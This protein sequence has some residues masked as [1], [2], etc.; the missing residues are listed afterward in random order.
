MYI[1]DVLNYIYLAIWDTQVG[2][3]DEASGKFCLVVIT[4]EGGSC[5]WLEKCSSKVISVRSRCAPFIVILLLETI[6]KSC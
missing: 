4:E 5:L 3:A 1:H 6:L 2:T